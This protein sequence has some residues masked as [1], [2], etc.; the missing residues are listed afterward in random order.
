M[1]VFGTIE[2]V[3]SYYGVGNGSLKIPFDL[4][5]MFFMRD[6]KDSLFV[7]PAEIKKMVDQWMVN[8]PQDGTANW[9]VSANI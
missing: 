8:M 7:T 4:Q 3:T 6:I 1:E 5:F 9:V 2:E